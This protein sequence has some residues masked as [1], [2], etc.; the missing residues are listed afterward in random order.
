ML[1]LLFASLGII[2]VAL[3]VLGIF[4]PFL[5]TTP[6][7]LLAAFLF[8]RSSRRLHDWLLSHRHLG[9]YIHAW[10]NRTGLTPVQKLRIG[11][12]FTLIMAVSIA[13]CPDTLWGHWGRM[14]LTAVWAFW[15]IM[16]WR[17]KVA[18]ILPPESAPVRT[19]AV[20]SGN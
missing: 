18:E 15:I 12:S 19:P 8:A 3:A 17:L 4:L 16:L 11:L 6:F 2:T 14:G 13:L 1:R 7:L 10:R 20:E 5:P 9:P